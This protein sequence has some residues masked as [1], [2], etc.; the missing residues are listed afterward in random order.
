MACE[1]LGAHVGQHKRVH[2]GMRRFGDRL[3]ERLRERGARLAGASEGLHREI[4]DREQA[5]VRL[6]LAQARLDA[7]QA[8]GL[9]RPLPA[10]PA[11]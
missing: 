8:D 11:L 4:T 10:G 9:P 3:E 1:Q 5:E 6:V 2:N 7:F